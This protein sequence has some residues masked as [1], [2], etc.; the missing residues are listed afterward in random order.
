MARARNIKPAFF[1]NEYLAESTPHAR[2]LFIGLW[3]LADREGRLEC[4]P[5]RIRA[6]LFAYENVDI[7]SL[8]QELVG[9]EFVQVYEIGGSKY[10]QIANWKKHQNPHHKEIASIIPAMEGHKDTV[11][12]G[13]FPL[14][15]T[16][17]DR[18]YTRD[19]RVCA[20]CGVTEDLNIDHI[21]AISKNGNSNDENLQV[22]C[23]SCNL[24]KGDNTIDFKEFR[25][26][27]PIIV[28][29]WFKHESYLTQAWFKEIASTPTDPLNLNP[30]SPTLIPEVSPSGSS[31]K[32]AEP[33]PYQQIVDSYN[34]H[35]PMLRRCIKVTD[36]VR[37]TIRK[38]WNADKRHQ[39]F[40]FWDRYFS[41]IPQL[42]KRV[43]FWSGVETG[44][45]QGIDVIARQA[46]FERTIE[47]L[48]ALRG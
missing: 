24:K 17:R 48:V 19:G 12:D 45:K 34:E 3:M 27:D 16:I 14:N 35:L 5:K 8:I 38:S 1:D 6:Q 13:Y 36:K 28:Q 46:I 33:I 9:F 30:D 10:M 11:C 31:A 29:A 18:I 22:L 2:L 43:E 7:D 15:Q 44:T 41:A 32:R 23:K 40:K 25:N 47:E 42:T 20:C 4:R 26:N 21:V 37:D 39:S